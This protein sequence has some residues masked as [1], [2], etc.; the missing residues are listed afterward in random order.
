MSS[1]LKSLAR[2]PDES[3]EVQSTTKGL[4]EKFGFANNAL[5]PQETATPLT[6]A[7][8]IRRKISESQKISV[9][10]EDGGGSVASEDRLLPPAAAVSGGGNDNWN[11]PIK[12]PGQPQPD[13]GWTPQGGPPANSWAGTGAQQQ[14]PGGAP[15]PGSDIGLAAPGTDGWSAD[16]RAPKGTS[17]G[18]DES[19]WGPPPAGGAW[20]DPSGG[21]QQ[22][23]SWGGAPAAQQSGS[24]GSPPA[25]GA[26]AP[27]AAAAQSSDSSWGAGAQASWATSPSPTQPTSDQFGSGGWNVPSA[28]EN[29]TNAPVSENPPANSNWGGAPAG[30]VSLIS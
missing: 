2:E 5:N 21:G 9:E 30:G 4:G 25:G 17:P 10:E 6:L 23:Q 15:H 28:K 11:A 3:R 19:G 1:R 24:W 13:P 7:E 12:M 27:A 22:S 14:Q 18:D 20:E 29:Q 8:S 16:K 26:P